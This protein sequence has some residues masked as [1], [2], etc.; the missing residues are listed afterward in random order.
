MEAEVLNAL[1]DPAG[2][3]T[4]PIVFLVL[5]V[6]TFALHIAAVQIMLGASSLTLWGALSKNSYRRQLADDM[7]AVAKVM[8]S[9]AIVIGVAPLL[10]VQVVYDP[11]WYVSNVL[12]AW[13]VIGFI[14]VLI[15]GYLAMYWFYWQNES[16]IDNPTKC[17]GSMLIA[18]ALLLTV[19]F[20]MHVLTSQ[21][22]QPDQWMTWYAP[23]GVLDTSGRHIHAYNLSR[24]A[25]FISLSVPVIGAFL[26]AYRRYLRVKPSADHAYLDWVG[27]LAMKAITLGGVLSL[28]IGAVWLSGLE[29]SQEAFATSPWVML[30][31]VALLATVAY[32]VWT[33][34]NARDSFHSYFVLAVGA[35]ALIVV[36]AARELFRWSILVDGFGFDA[37]NYPLNLDW[38]STILFFTTFAVV[39]GSVLGYFL[40]VS[41]QAGQTEGVYTPSPVVTKLGKA[42]LAIVVLWIVQFF[43]VGFY[44]WM[45]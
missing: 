16:L 14:G 38:Y 25:F 32:S 6:L 26:L 44:V 24:F 37:W 33:W 12:S 40:T 20:I 4:H 11:F 36:A 5:G 27:G 3:P 10:F 13:W 9:V 19:G 23:N 34:M 7:L 22:L 30:S 31:A 18:L 28:V 21:M 41:W 45:R 29:G 42:A 17:P 39:G 43:A 15:A 35:V 2:L 1:R 8:L